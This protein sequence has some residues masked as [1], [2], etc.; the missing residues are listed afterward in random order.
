M[1]KILKQIKMQV[2]HLVNQYIRLHNETHQ[3]LM[4]ILHIL[5]TWKKSSIFILNHTK[6]LKM[7]SMSN[8]HI[9]GFSSSHR[10][11]TGRLKYAIHIAKT[12]THHHKHSQ[13]THTCCNT[14]C[15]QISTEASSSRLD[16]LVS[17]MALLPAYEVGNEDDQHQPSKRRANNDGNKHLVLIHLTLLR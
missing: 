9:F 6:A 16:R 15:S 8:Q 11:R 2:S 12:C 10:E 13:V 1:D 4:L 17:S 7:H 3:W 14:T 5:K